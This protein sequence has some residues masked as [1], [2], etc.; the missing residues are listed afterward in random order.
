MALKGEAQG[1]IAACQG[2][3]CPV[4]ALT[5]QEMDRYFDHMLYMRV[6]ELEL[7]ADIRAAWG[8]CTRH[9]HKLIRPAGAVGTAIIYHDVLTNLLHALDGAQ[10]GEGSGLLRLRRGDGAGALLADLA[11]AQPCPACEHQSA[12]ERA[13]VRALVKYL[14]TEREP[15]LVA[16]YEQSDAL[17]W[18]HLRAALAVVRHA[19][20]FARLM[21]VQRAAWRRL[22]AELAEFIRKNDH[23]FQREE[24]GTEGDSWQRVIQ[25][26]AG[27]LDVGGV[28]DRD[29]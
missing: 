20:T 27:L 28:E 2:K 9:A 25:Q 22:S 3:G 16:A 4:C 13:Y 15:E 6:N 7:R 5:A 26:V 18:R 29:L 14:G 8:F 17:C 12:T 10:W 24:M 23:R 19:D 1:L 11:P 21:H